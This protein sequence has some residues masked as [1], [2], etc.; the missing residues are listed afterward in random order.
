[1]NDE[2]IEKVLKGPDGPEKDR[3]IVAALKGDDQRLQTR[4]AG[5]LLKDL[6][7]K[8]KLQN[9]T[10]QNSGTTDDGAEMAC[11]AVS[12]LY[13]NIQ[14]GTYRQRDDRPLV[15]YCFRIG[16][17]KWLRI[18]K[19]RGKWRGDNIDDPDGYTP[20]D[21]HTDAD[22]FDDV[23]ED[24]I[25][26]PAMQKAWRAYKKLGPTC[27]RLVKLELDGLI[28]EDVLKEYPTMTLAKLQERRQNCK[29]AWIDLVKEEPPL[30][31][32]TEVEEVCLDKTFDGLTP[33]QRRLIELDRDGL[34]EEQAQAVLE[35]KTIGAVRVY[36]ARAKDRWAELHATCMNG[37]NKKPT[38]GTAE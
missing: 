17:L 3:A 6:E 30:G 21:P 34:S 37:H 4:A 10:R 23:D 25:T 35:Y 14:R 1:M 29:K 32:G 26:S 36:R 9:Y 31:I 19:E 28:D 16:V 27:Q 33:G 18:L 15:G 12:A 7:L 2:E 38:D 8:R 13:D 20:P 5:V 22:P 11:E 24:K